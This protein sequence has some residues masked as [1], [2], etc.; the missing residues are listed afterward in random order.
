[1]RQ[2]A[3]LSGVRPL[4]IWNRTR[5]KAERLAREHLLRVF[6]T[7]DQMLAD[8]QITLVHVATAPAMHHEHVMAALRAGKHVLCE[9]PLATNLS[10]A[11]EMIATARSRQLQLGINFVMRYGPL[12]EPVRR[13]IQVGALGEVLHGYLVNC[14]GDDKLHEE[15]WFWDRAQSGGIFVGHGVHFFDLLRSWL[16]KGTVT[17]AYQ[18]RRP[19]TQLIDQVHCAVRYGPQASVTFYHGFHQPA[20]IDRQE[21]RLIFERGDV[22]LNGWIPDRIRIHAVVDQRSS[23]ELRAVFPEARISTVERYSQRMRLCRSRGVDYEVDE[24]IIVEQPYG[25]DSQTIYGHAVRA[26]LEDFVAAIAEPAHEP[27]V[28]AQD[29][30]DALALALEADRV[31]RRPGSG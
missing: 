6:D 29:A 13:L 22:A 30:R 28:S 20:R 25:P 3:G 9:K 19:G 26:L 21:I 10:D 11:D 23:E 8:E 12:W 31:A 2:L 18:V 7:L 16:G 24:R 15:H 5:S 4:A 14:A 17:N 27:R 1:M